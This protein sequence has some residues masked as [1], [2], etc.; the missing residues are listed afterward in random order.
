MTKY[1][2]SLTSEEELRKMVLTDEEELDSDDEDEELNDEDDQR[3]EDGEVCGNCGGEFEKE[4]G[5]PALCKDCWKTTSE[6][7]HAGFIESNSD[8]IAAG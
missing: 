8:V 6:A 4:Q 1:D 3:I 7:D 5:E 2:V